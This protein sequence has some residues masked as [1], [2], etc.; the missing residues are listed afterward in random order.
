MVEINVSRLNNHSSIENKFAQ[1][2]KYPVTT[3]DFNF[4]LPKDALYST[5]ESIANV[6]D[7]G[8]SYKCELLD[9]FHNKADNTNSYTLRYYVTSMDHT[10]SSREIE[11]FHKNVIDTFKANGIAL[12]TE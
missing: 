7:T 12:K 11:D 9:I 5:I 4:I 2:S 1:V 8:L 3:L 10:L 6:I